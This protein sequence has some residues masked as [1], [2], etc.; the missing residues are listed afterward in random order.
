[1]F[2][3]IMQPDVRQWEQLKSKHEKENEGSAGCS[4]FNVVLGK[5]LICPLNTFFFWLKKKKK[6][7][8]PRPEKT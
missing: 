5:S 1:M 8:L 3:V 4:L 6:K 7:G 2:Q